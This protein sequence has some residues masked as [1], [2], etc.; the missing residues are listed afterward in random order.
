[1][2]SENQLARNPPNF[3]NNNIWQ[4]VFPLDSGFPASFFNAADRNYKDLHIRATNPNDPC[5]Y[6]Q[7]WS[8]G[9]Q[10]ERASRSVPAAELRSFC[11]LGSQETASPKPGCQAGLAIPF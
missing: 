5:S 7:Q 4:P 1:L 2:P 3:I 9:V 11:V 10:R 6:M 8:F